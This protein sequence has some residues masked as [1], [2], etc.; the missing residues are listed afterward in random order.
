MERGGGG[1][2]HQLR[3]L[4]LALSL[5]PMAQKEHNACRASI[6]TG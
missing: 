5:R 3:A 4:P 1:D 6:I 2:R